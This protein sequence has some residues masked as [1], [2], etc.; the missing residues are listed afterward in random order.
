[1]RRLWIGVVILLALL[2]SGLWAAKR[3]EDI[4]GSIASELAQAAAVLETENWQRADHL[5]DSA[6]RNWESN[7]KFTASMADHN[8]LD[9]IDSAFAQLE[10]YRLS[11]NSLLCAATSA[12]LSQQVAALEEGHNLNWWNLF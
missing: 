7:W 5:L 10:V 9:Q 11:R 2:I 3:M 1:M 8:T 6:K 12:Q 4:H